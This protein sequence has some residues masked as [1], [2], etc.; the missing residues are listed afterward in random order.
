MWGDIVR[1]DMSNFKSF[2]ER[3]PLRYQMLGGRGFT[4]KVVLEEV[5]PTCY[6]LGAKNKIIFSPGLLGDIPLAPCSGRLSA[7]AKSP[8]TGGIK[9]ANSG[10]TAAYRMARLG[11]RALIIEGK[12][13]KNKW[14]LLKLAKDGVEI[15]PANELTEL[16]NY[17]LVEK[18]M[19]SYGKKIS[20]ISIGQ[21]GERLFSLASIA[22]TDTLNKPSRYLARGGLGAVLGSKGIKAIIIDDKGVEDKKS[23]YDEGLFKKICKEHTKRLVETKQVLTKYGTMCS[24][25]ESQEM[26]CLPVR[27][28]REGTVKELNKVSGEALYNRIKERGGKISYG[29]MIG[30]P[31]KCANLYNDK[32]RKYLVSTFEYESFSLLGLNCGISDFDTVGYLNRLC[33]DYGMDTIE[34][35]ATIAILMEAGLLS[36]GDGEGAIKMIEEVRKNTILGKIIGQ[37]AAVTAKVFGVDRA[38]VVKGQAMAA[39]DPRSNKG[40]GV[41]FATSPMGADHTAGCALPGRKGMRDDLNLDPHNSKDKVKLSCDLQTLIAA[42]D[43]SGFCYF[44]GLAVED[45]ERIAKLIKARYGVKV[46]GEDMINIGKTTLKDEREFNRRVGFT[47]V[48]DRLPEF[49]YKEKLPP[50]NT[51][52]DISPEE[53]DKYFNL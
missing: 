6:P 1:I 12:P 20:I 46:T 36:F 27:N 51:V 32:G 45:L 21:A 18:I 53:I 24:V 33:N 52:F 41:T 30:C 14:Y 43:T 22:V 9:E 40:T 38:P 29:C 31:I 16:G 23:F 13:S 8:L 5:K 3:V 2:R 50:F 47:K 19:D 49:F 42:V 10:G 37:G 34:T 17:Q 35:G 48:D 4:S 26:G 11:I 44:S 25:E 28:F 15:L 39:Y 7:G